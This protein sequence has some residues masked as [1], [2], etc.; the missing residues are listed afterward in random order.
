MYRVLQMKFFSFSCSL[1][2]HTAEKGAD[3]EPGDTYAIH[4]FAFD[5]AARSALLDCCRRRPKDRAFTASHS[6]SG[7][8]T[9]PRMP[10]RP[11]GEPNCA[12]RPAL[13]VPSRPAYQEATLARNKQHLCLRVWLVYAASWPPLWSRRR[14]LYIGQPRAGNR[15]CTLGSGLE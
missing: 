14:R 9:P 10:S 13:M 4:T 3:T 2:L 15:A 1:I 8:F 5:L 7:T 6:S 12:T 11:A